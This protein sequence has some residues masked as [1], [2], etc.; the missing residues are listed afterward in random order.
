LQATVGICISL[1]LSLKRLR[2]DQWAAQVGRLVSEFD[3]HGGHQYRRALREAVWAV[4]YV[5]CL[6]GCKRYK[7]STCRDMCNKNTQATSNRSCQ[8]ASPKPG[9]P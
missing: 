4:C 9:A 2:T 7:L 6:K 1:G 3:L 8:Y 5:S